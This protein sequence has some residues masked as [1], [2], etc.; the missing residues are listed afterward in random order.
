MFCS[1]ATCR[2][3]GST[4]TPLRYRHGRYL[5]ISAVLCLVLSLTFDI[6]PATAQRVFRRV[7]RYGWASEQ[8]LPSSHISQAAASQRKSPDPRIQQPASQDKSVTNRS[9]TAKTG[10]SKTVPAPPNA[11]QKNAAAKIAA[12]KSETPKSETPRSETPKAANESGRDQPEGPSAKSAASGDEAEPTIEAEA[13]NEVLGEGPDPLAQKFAEI[14]ARRRAE[15]AAA[16]AASTD[17]RKQSSAEQSPEGGEPQPTAAVTEE[18][19]AEPMTLD[20]LVLRRS[21]E[22]AELPRTTQIGRL[23]LTGDDFSNRALRGLEGLKV[24]EL[25]IEAADVSHPG[26][27]Y[28]PSVQGLLRLRLWTPALDDAALVHVAKVSTLEILDVEGTSIDGSGLVQL[29]KLPKLEMLVLGPQ[30]SDVQVA[31]LQQLPALR[32]LDLRACSRLSLACLDSLALLPDLKVLWLPSHIRDKGKRALRK[33]L[34][35]CDVRS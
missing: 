29:Q 12:P 17:P 9:G 31:S 8:V 26:L 5:L 25:S 22:L 27:Q 15:V 11:G 4:S 2:G 13:A 1:I 14:L 34:P 6:V 35:T 21:Q 18:T 28:L 7:P 23:I 16:T 30:V 20:V 19:P 32:Q 3:G 10:Q 33:S 24:S